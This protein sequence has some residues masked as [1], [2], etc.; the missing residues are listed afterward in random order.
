MIASATNTV[1]VIT[2]A[3]A[4][5][6]GYYQVN[7]GND[8]GSTNSP[9]IFL[10]VVPMPPRITAQP[11]SL[12]VFAGGTAVLPS[13]V[14]GSEPLALQW[15]K[16]GTALYEA[17][18]PQLV[19][20]NAQAADSGIYQ[21]AATN[22][23]GDLVSTGATLTVL[24]AKP[25][26]I[27]QPF[28]TATNL[29]DDVEFSCLAGGSNDATN[30]LSFA[31]YFQGSLLSGQTGNTL[32]LSSITTSNQG[33]YFVVASNAYGLA[34]S[35]IARLTVD[36]PPALATGLTNVVADE[37]GTV[38]FAASAAGTPPLAYNWS[39]NYLPLTNQTATLTL[40]NVTPSQS[41]FYAI[42]VT[43]PSGSISSTGRLS[44]SLP[45]CKVVGWGDDSGGQT[46][47]PNN[48]EDAVG[49]AGGDY[50]SLVLHHDG[51]ITSW[52]LDDLDAPTNSLRYVAVAAG[53]SHALGV[54][55]D[56]SMA[57][58]GRDDTGQAEVPY[59]TVN[60][61]SVAAGDAHSLA[62]LASGQVLAW[63][64]NTYGQ[65]NLP[66][67]LQLSGYWENFPPWEWVTLY[68]YPVQAIAAHS[69]HSLALL[70]NGTVAAWGDNKFGESTVPANLSNVVAIAA[71]YLH[72]T[73]L[74]A[75]GTVVAWGDNTF[76][77]TNVP[78]GLSNVV[79]IAAGD[80]HTLALLSNGRIVGWGDNSLGQAMAPSGLPGAA[81]IACGYFHNL[82]LTP[83]LQLKGHL[84]SGQM[85]LDWGAGILQWSPALFG[86]YADLPSQG[87]SYTNFNSLV[88]PTKFFRVRY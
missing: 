29:G 66:S 87:G 58:W 13:S 56:G 85:V 20:S 44:V 80:F 17:T 70:T 15:L 10:R 54:F 7:L 88:A 48:L 78:L 76:G 30:V 21:L 62:L 24:P 8:L 45:A 18:M 77:Q 52:G 50:Y 79:A 63:G 9:L 43:S 84:A 1:L 36:L 11:G 6:E 3:Q 64:D 31:W 49:V 14:L 5:N 27:V 86:P 72:S 2:N 59:G 83:T 4:V 69:D 82:A 35:E 39:F 22:Y 53:A 73:A 57:A 33:D 34:T 65:L 23:W 46:D 12:M 68:P 60:V 19:I 40:S 26:F 37:G 75:D 61:L 41:G 32:L 74:R 16:D 38:T 28:S 51:T 47:V 42:S 71:G 25:W 81:E 67:F 55:D